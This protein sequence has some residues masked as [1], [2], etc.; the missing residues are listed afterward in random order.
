MKKEECGSES[1]KRGMQDKKLKNK[2]AEQ[3]RKKKNLEL[4]T[5][6][7]ESTTE[8]AGKLQQA[9]GQSRV[10]TQC[11]LTDTLWDSETRNTTYIDDGY[12]GERPWAMQ[13]YV[14]LRAYW[15]PQRAEASMGQM[16]KRSRRMSGKATE[17]T[18]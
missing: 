14:A 7:E 1:S 13:L 15:R 8:K 11:D 6:I 18:E 16:I 2:N 10:D 17:V 3:K 9:Q 12:T 4:K 5:K